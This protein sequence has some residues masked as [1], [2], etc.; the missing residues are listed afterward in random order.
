[1]LTFHL[2]HNDVLFYMV[3]KLHKDVEYHVREGPHLAAEPQ[4]RQ[5]GMQ[6]QGDKHYTLEIR[7]SYRSVSI[8]PERRRRVGLSHS[9][10][11]VR[12]V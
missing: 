12:E 6:L 9:K 2:V 11:Q 5:Q 1:M 8:E 4:E 3:V 7:G 10:V